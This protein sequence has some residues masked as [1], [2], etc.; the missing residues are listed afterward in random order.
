ML[1]RKIQYQVDRANHYFDKNKLDDALS[2]W[3]AALKLVP[4]PRVSQPGLNVGVIFSGIGD[5]YFFKAEYNKAKVWFDQSLVITDIGD[6]AMAYLQLRL[7][8]IHYELG[9]FSTSRDYFE[10][11]MTL[12]G[13]VHI[14][15]GEDIKYKN[16]II[17]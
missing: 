2:Y 3:M 10:M 6:K 4:L 17:T 1:N 14:F 5:C 16:S 11:A 7:G 12:S 15:D 8:M 13:G 9:N